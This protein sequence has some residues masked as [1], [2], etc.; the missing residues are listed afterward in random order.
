MFAAAWADFQ[1]NMWL[2]LSMPITSGFVGYIT[3]VIALKMM[4]H[5]LEFFGIKPP[6]LGWQGIVPRKAGKM[7]SIACDTIV[8]RLVS[9]R[10]I[11]SRLDP[12]RVAQEIEGP[13]VQLVDQLLE[14]LMT[15]YEPTLWETLP[16]SARALIAK[17]VKNDAPDVVAAVMDDFKTHVD[18]I[19]DLKDMVVTTLMR[20]KSLINKIFLETG[21]QEFIFI[22]RSGFYFGFVFGILQ[23]IGWT[24]FKAQWQLPL[25]GLIVGY[26]TNVIALQMIFRPQTPMRFLGT[27]IH[28]LF[29]KRQKEV[30]RDYARLIADEIMTPS[31]IIES[32][33]KGPYAD[34]VFNMI[35]KHVKKVIDDQSGLARPFVAWTIGTR[36]YMDMKTT[37]AHRIVRH[38][39]EAT[40][41]IDAYAKEAMSIADT[42]ASRLEVLPAPEFEGML[43]PAFKE[44]EWILITVGAVLGFIVGVGQ[45]VLFS[46]VGKAPEA[47]ATPEALGA[48][49]SLGPVAQLLQLW[50]WA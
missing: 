15:E 42:L 44:D 23:M 2:Y 3:N 40:R 11:F 32:V 1:L 14:E 16:L 17:R 18:T 13:I 38:L 19:F 21:K 48:L 6:Y 28:G 29:F 34:R 41:K 5:P 12:Q 46:V 24:F 49:E 27:T 50:P 35:S 45:L 36:R 22:E 37:A 4:F 31:N 10:E 20:D 8:P 9:E 47:A 39:P 43:R 7:A 33:L 30:S 26:A 25:F